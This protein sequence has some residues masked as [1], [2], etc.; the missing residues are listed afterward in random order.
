VSRLIVCWRTAELLLDTVLRPP[1]HPFLSSRLVLTYFLLPRCA[2]F[3][4]GVRWPFRS[5]HDLVSQI[6]P[7][8]P[9]KNDRPDFPWL[10]HGREDPDFAE[11]S[12]RVLLFPFFFPFASW[13]DSPMFFVC[14]AGSPSL[15]DGARPVSRQLVPSWTYVVPS[16][17]SLP[18]SFV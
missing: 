14:L 12:R 4:G 1:P 18:L 7:S 3:M 8:T 11:V 5:G 15:P 17:V 6:F 10:I 9:V 16:R 13:E 2:S